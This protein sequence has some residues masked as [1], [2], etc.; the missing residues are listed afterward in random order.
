MNSLT[1][2]GKIDLLSEKDEYI[3][4]F[5]IENFSKKPTAGIYSDKIT[6]SIK[7]HL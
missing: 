6:F 3:A 7:T 1:E 4:N 5:K 2:N